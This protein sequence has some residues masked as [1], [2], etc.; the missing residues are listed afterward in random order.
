M[1]PQKSRARARWE[2]AKPP[3][4]GQFPA[5]TPKPI[6]SQNEYKDVL[7]PTKLSSVFLEHCPYIRTPY[8]VNDSTLALNN[9]SPPWEAPDDESV[10][11]SYV[12]TSFSVNSLAN[13]YIKH[14]GPVE[15][16]NGKYQGRV[17]P[18]IRLNGFFSIPDS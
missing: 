11:N 5:I 13:F 14:D 1:G 12:R 17:A 7:N 4:S 6:M 8:H 16:K 18:Q 9:Q 3:P 2:A 15:I 10:A